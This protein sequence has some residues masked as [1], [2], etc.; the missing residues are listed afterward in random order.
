[1][2]TASCTSARKPGTTNQIQESEFMLSNALRLAHTLIASRAI[3][4]IVHDVFVIIA[5]CENNS[6]YA[7]S[8]DPS[9]LVIEGCGTRD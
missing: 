1:M 8:P 6:L 7:R 4:A 9:F 5:F 2:H 3:L